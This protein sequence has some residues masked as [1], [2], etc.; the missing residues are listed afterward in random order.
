MSLESEVRSLQE[1][2]MFRD[3]EPARLKLMAFASDRVSFATEETLFRQGDPSD[4]AYVILD[5]QA[6]VRLNTKDKF[7][8]VATLGKSA[9][10]GEMGVLTGSPRSATVVASTDLV[11][12]RIR[13]DVFFDMVR[14][15]PA[16]AISVMRDLAGRLERTN[17]RL[18]ET[19]AAR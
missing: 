8:S 10:V 17:A 3:I 1:V 19:L 14:E 5:G 12:L 18:A 6:D 13:K 11:A 2:P 15:F 9:I 16:M 7:F 4:S